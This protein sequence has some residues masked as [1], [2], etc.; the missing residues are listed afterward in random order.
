LNIAPNDDIVYT[1]ICV[2]RTSVEK[3]SVNSL[4][5]MKRKKCE[6]PLTDQEVMRAEQ[7]SLTAVIS[8]HEY[9]H[10]S[11]ST[12]NLEQFQSSGLSCLTVVIV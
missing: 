11:R 6:A 3:M 5:V 8:T 9:L 10:I 12:H 4:K 7:H 1:H 2:V